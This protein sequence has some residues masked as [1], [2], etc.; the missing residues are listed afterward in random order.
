M[1]YSTVT[2]ISLKWSKN[3]QFFQN[4]LTFRCP[5]HISSS[6]HCFSAILKIEIVFF[7]YHHTNKHTSVKI[8]SLNF[9]LLLLFFYLLSLLISIQQTSERQSVLQLFLYFYLIFITE[10]KKEKKLS[11]NGAESVVLTI[12]LKLLLNFRFIRWDTA[13]WYLHVHIECT[14]WLFRRWNTCKHEYVAFHQ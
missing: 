11:K 1:I 5:K 12:G 9:V 3:L 4:R 8:R 7:C 13:L 2:N 14:R 10:A 6:F